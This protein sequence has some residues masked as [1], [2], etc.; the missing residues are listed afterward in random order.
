MQ[1]TDLTQFPNTNNWRVVHD[2]DS[3]MYYLKNDNGNRKPGR[4][5]NRV[6]AEK[7]L[8][9]YL[10]SVADAIAKQKANPKEKVDG[11]TQRTTRKKQL[12]P[13]TEQAS[14]A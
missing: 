7:A 2:A 11:R 9:G 8:Y 6:F 5:T 1:P 3:Q 14:Q 12:Q 4:Y 10:K 13:R